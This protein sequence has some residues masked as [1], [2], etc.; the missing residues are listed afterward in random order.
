MFTNSY[1]F[2]AFKSRQVLIVF[3]FLSSSLQ[4]TVDTVEYSRR[5][6]GKVKGPVVVSDSRMSS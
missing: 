5:S 4:W 1:V 3:C 2:S 6:L